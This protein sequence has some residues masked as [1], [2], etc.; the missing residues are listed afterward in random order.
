MEQE[1]VTNCVKD[2]RR[3]WPKITQKTFKTSGYRSQT[4]QLKI[5]RNSDEV[6]YSSY[7][8]GKAYLYSK[9]FI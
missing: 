4:G 1:E 2:L 8:K 6:W 5:R 9:P 3:D 7:H